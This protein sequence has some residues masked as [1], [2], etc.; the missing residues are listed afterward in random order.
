MRAKGADGKEIIDSLIQNSSTYNMKTQFSKEK[1]LKK[2]MQKY[3]VTFE[4]ME[5]TASALCEL[6]FL[7]KPVQIC[8]LRP[9]MLGLLLNMANV[10]SESQVLFV[11]NT[12]GLIHTACV[13]KK[14]K[15]GL[16]V[17]FG[18]GSIKIMNE[19]LD[20]AQ[21]T[22]DANARIGTVSAN[23]LVQTGKTADPLLAGMSK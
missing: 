12:R 3:M 10:H 20:Y 21:C 23:V 18:E 2:K 7:T 14:V 5:P 17:E 6:Y 11:E 4:V 1:W 13:E 22:A 8:Y 16:R 19:I 15:Y 9:D